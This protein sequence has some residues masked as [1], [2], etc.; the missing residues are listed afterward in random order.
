MSRVRLH[1]DKATHVQHIN[2]RT[3]ESTRPST[4]LGPIP[5]SRL[6]VNAG[7]SC[8]R[9]NTVHPRHCI[10]T[11]PA[12]IPTIPPWEN[13][14]PRPCTGPSTNAPCLLDAPDPSVCSSLPA[15]FLWMAR[16]PSPPSGRPCTGSR[17][18]TGS[19]KRAQRRELR[20]LTPDADSRVNFS[21]GLA[22][23]KSKTLPSD[24]RTY[25]KLMSHGF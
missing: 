11:R 19:E 20:A 4:Y 23:D 22:L 10:S 1:P 21:V 15:L 3:R 24:M 17:A 8:Q 25:G 12:Q 6:A 14:H 18:G 5:T 9:R 16:G 13:M 2:G 7:R